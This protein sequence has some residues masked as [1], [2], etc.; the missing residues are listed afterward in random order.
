MAQNN[1]DYRALRGPRSAEKL[2]VLCN[3]NT[4]L[5]NFISLSRRVFSFDQIGCVLY[6]FKAFKIAM[7]QSKMHPFFARV[8]IRLLQISNLL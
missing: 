7:N 8:R 4:A 1:R 2:G 5:G 6:S 3:L